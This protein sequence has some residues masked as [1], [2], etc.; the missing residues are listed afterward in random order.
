MRFEIDRASAPV[1]PRPSQRPV[2]GAV[3]DGENWFIEIG[4]LDELMAL[5]AKEGTVI[6]RD[7]GLTIYDDYVE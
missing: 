4:T 5:I 2:E 6:L 7:D 1:I 3:L